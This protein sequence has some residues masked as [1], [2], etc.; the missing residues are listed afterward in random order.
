MQGEPV[1]EKKLFQYRFPEPLWGS[2]ERFIENLSKLPVWVNHELSATVFGG[3]QNMDFW[4]HIFETSKTTSG[5]QVLS[6]KINLMQMI[7]ES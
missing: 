2:I 3:K 5:Q 6:E 7:Q 1:D 4:Q